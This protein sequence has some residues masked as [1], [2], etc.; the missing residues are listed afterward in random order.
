MP[1][2]DSLT[3]VN[4]IM[5]PVIGLI[6]GLLF[7]PAKRYVKRKLDERD[8]KRKI[9]VEMDSATRKRPNF[10]ITQII[11][12]EAPSIDFSSVLKKQNQ[13]QNLVRFSIDEFLRYPA[14]GA[15]SELKLLSQTPVKQKGSKKAALGIL[16]SI[17]TKIGNRQWMGFSD[18]PPGKE[19]DTERNLIVTNIPLP[20]RFFA[21][22]SRD[23]TWL[24][25]STASVLRF[26][27]EEDKPGIRDFVVRI[28]QRMTVFALVPEL[29]PIH[30]HVGTAEGCLFDFNVRLEGI[31]DV[32]ASPD[33][34]PVCARA[35][36]E[37]QSAEFLNGLLEWLKK[38]PAAI[39]TPHV[40][41]ATKG[42]VIADI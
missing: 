41:G 3:L 40:R 29:D 36:K 26:F 8:E 12:P 38:T 25:I 31:A 39:S 6:I 18:K 5:G 17:V 13:L 7:E 24:V 2:I 15:L 23:R 34:C 9:C 11:D 42:E 20:D 22:N 4:W 16:A 32:V 19:I 14:A 37:E 35:I 27:L 30:T 28:M 33:V 10:K 21:W 1:E